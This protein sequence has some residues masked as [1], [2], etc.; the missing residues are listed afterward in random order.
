MLPHG[1]VYAGTSRSQVHSVNPAIA[2][3][4]V[5]NI[6][7]YA[8]FGIPWKNEIRVV[9]CALGCAPDVD[10]WFSQAL[11]G[12]KTDHE[13]GPFSS[14]CCPAGAPPAAQPTCS[15]HGL[16]GAPFSGQS[17]DLSGRDGAFMLGPLRRLGYPVLLAQDVVFPF[18]KTHG[19]RLNVFL[20]VEI[21][22]YPNIGDGAGHGIVRARPGS[23]PF[24]GEHTGRVIVEGIDKDHLYPYVLQPLAAAGA[25]KGRVDPAGGLRVA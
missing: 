7:G 2:G 21:F 18:V 16:L 25:L 19:P 17:L 6:T 9:R 10:A 1:A 11:H 8:S 22:G 13:A 20:V 23:K 14:G 15:Q 12:L 5:V 24:V 3:R 4:R